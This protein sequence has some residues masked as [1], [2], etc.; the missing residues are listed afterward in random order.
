MLESHNDIEGGSASG[1]EIRFFKYEH[2]KKAVEYLAKLEFNNTKI[3]VREM[4][5]AGDGRS[6]VLKFNSYGASRSEILTYVSTI[7]KAI[8]LACPLSKT[9]TVPE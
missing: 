2:A 5:Y 8:S 7:S 1:I 9:I 3:A 4:F 6:L